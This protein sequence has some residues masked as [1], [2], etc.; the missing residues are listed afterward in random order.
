MLCVGVVG[1]TAWPC[2]VHLISCTSCSVTTAGLIGGVMLSVNGQPGFLVKTNSA[3]N[4]LLCLAAQ[5]GGTRSTRRRTSGS[6]RPSES[7]AQDQGPGGQGPARHLVQGQGL[8][9]GLAPASGPHRGRPCMWLE[10]KETPHEPLTL[11]IGEAMCWEDSSCCT[12]AC[13]Q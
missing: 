8:V 13:M 2:S 10:R 5:A 11:L 3:I 6:A 1:V 9:P 12:T 4:T 7:L